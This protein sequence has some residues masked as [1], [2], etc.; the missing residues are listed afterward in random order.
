MADP[1][2]AKLPVLV[3]ARKAANATDDRQYDDFPLMM[4]A[5]PDRLCLPIFS[6]TTTVDLFVSSR[7][8]YGDCTFPWVHKDALL[9]VL[10]F[11]KQRH[12]DFDAVALDPAFPAA[13]L[14]IGAV[15]LHEF[16]SHLESTA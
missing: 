10:D 1:R 2:S 13:G 14:P 6:S 8:Y 15:S 11:V 3:M 16:R 12:P 9:S 4:L 5:N 7:A